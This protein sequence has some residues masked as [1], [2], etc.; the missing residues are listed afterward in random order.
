[1]KEE[2]RVEVENEC[3]NFSSK[4]YVNLKALTWMSEN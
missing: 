1:M 3:M 2:A 4:G